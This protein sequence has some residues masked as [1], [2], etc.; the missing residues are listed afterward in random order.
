MNL[1]VDGC[2]EDGEAVNCV[3]LVICHGPPSLRRFCRGSGAENV[4]MAVV[5]RTASVVNCML[6]NSCRVWRVLWIWIDILLL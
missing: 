3:N 1:I 4:V 6:F 5:R 2:F